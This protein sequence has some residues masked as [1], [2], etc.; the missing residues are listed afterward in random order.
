MNLR[1][2]CSGLRRPPAPSKLRALLEY[3]DVPPDIFLKAL[4]YVTDRGNGRAQAHV[5]VTTSGPSIADILRK[6]RDRVARM[7]AEA[8]PP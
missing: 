7:K 1:L 5:D 2:R 6:G 8:A 3:D 4:A